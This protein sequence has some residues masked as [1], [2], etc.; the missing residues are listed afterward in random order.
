MAI[1]RNI[2]MSFWTDAKVVD[3][4]TPEDRYFYLYLMTNPHTNLAGCYEISL[5]QIS[6]ETGYSK[7]TVLK[8]I[9]RMQKV[10]EVICYSEA[11]KEVLIVNW[12]EY[13]WT[14]SEK[15]RTPLYNEIQGIKNDD[16]RL[17][18]TDVYEGKDTVSIP[19]QYRTDTTVTVYNNHKYKD[20]DI[21]SSKVKNKEIIQE[22][23]S[24]LNIRTTS[25]FKWTTGATQKS[26]NGRL[27]DG[28]TVDDF[29]RVIDIKTAEWTGTDMEKHL[30][31]DTLFR[32]KNFE[33]Y[34][35]QN[36]PDIEI[37]MDALQKEMEE[38]YG[39]KNP[40]GPA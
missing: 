34:L 40:D 23:V 35:N 33:K 6:D 9:D 16:F 10:H 17:F 22:I 39:N 18:L 21:D 26:I 2:K 24:Y 14:K 25:S 8:L 11:T 20:I 32:Q 37:D 13:N 15:I 28:Y 36:M 3:E 30:N 27:N 31:P 1:Y 5:K 4:F 12:S 29:K 19:Y 7:D 38:K